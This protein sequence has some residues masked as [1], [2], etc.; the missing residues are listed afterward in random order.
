MGEEQ[1]VKDVLAAKDAEAQKVLQD[2][3]AKTLEAK[4]R[5]QTAES[6]SAEGTSWRQK[7]RDA[8]EA[9]GRDIKMLKE[10]REKNDSLVG[11]IAKLEQD[12]LKPA[13]Q[14]EQKGQKIQ[15]LSLP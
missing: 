5:I 3:N 2:A 14:R 15:Q 13:G 8:V 9:H 6:I 7:H 12:S 10:E 4:D 11:K 1:K